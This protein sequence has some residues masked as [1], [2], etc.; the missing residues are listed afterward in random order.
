MH[1]LVCHMPQYTALELVFNNIKK[2]TPG[3]AR[4][5]MKHYETTWHAEK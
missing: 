1:P 2:I 4:F 5:H 3:H